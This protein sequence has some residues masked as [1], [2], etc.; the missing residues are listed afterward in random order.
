MMTPSAEKCCWEMWWTCPIW[1]PKVWALER[2][3]G[4]CIWPIPHAQLEPGGVSS[5]DRL[6]F[7]GVSPSIRLP[8]KLHNASKKSTEDIKSANIL[9]DRLAAEWTVKGDYQY[10]LSISTK[11]IQ[12]M[13]PYTI[14][15]YI[16]INIYQ[17][18]QLIQLMYPYSMYFHVSSTIYCIH[19]KYPVDLSVFHVSRV[20]SVVFLKKKP[21]A[22][23]SKDGRLWF[24]H[25]LESWR[26]QELQGC[27]N[28]FLEK[29]IVHF[30][31]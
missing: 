10:P 28:R 31:P 12:L 9:L 2:P 19:K 27:A 23:Y 17:L 5:G 4:R 14:N 7:R 18:I 15:I 6:R 8:S 3:V 29:G 25:H 16:Y 13:Y 21:K 26:C 30:G 24:E 22:W 1:I 11:N 20:S